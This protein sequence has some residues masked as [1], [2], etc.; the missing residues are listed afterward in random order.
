MAP[1]SEDIDLQARERP[2]Q[3]A[4]H[5]VSHLRPQ[6]PT[7]PLR[8]ENGYRYLG[9]LSAEEAKDDSLLVK[10]QWLSSYH[11]GT[12]VGTNYGRYKCREEQIARF[13]DRTRFL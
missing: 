13:V 6:P 5:S 11:S 9:H 10:A 7:G 2:S 3:S 8:W 1:L 12:M 4:G